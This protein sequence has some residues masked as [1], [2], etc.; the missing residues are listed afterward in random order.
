MIAHG[1][2]DSG[3]PKIIR[4]DVGEAESEPFSREFLHGLVARGLIG[5]KLAISDA[6]PGS[7]RR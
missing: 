3:R 7:R 1:V 5:V 2:H 4:L 6:H